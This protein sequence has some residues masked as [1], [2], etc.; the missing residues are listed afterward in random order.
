MGALENVI[1]ALVEKK[2][3]IPYNDS[4][5]TRLLSTSIGGNSKTT[6]LVTCSPSIWNRDETISTLRFAKRAKKIKNKAKIN[7]HKTREQLEARI[8][9]L[10]NENRTLQI[11][12]NK[13]QFGGNHAKSLK[14]N[15]SMNLVVDGDAND[16]I[17]GMSMEEKQKNDELLQNKDEEINEHLDEIIKL[18]KE[19]AE[20]NDAMKQLEDELA[21]KAEIFYELE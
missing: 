1:N 3:H 14:M 21:S 15:K 19:M 16:Q 8:I 11:K 7:K 9:Y 20:K 13:K 10:E 18:K 4:K 12:L 5:L 17:F 2:K 6:L